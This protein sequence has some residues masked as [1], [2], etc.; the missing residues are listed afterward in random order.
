MDISWW[1]GKVGDLS[2]TEFLELNHVGVLQPQENR[3]QLAFN[4]GAVYRF[5]YSTPWKL[6]RLSA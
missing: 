1:L 6:N 2:E 5:A 3:E 4:S